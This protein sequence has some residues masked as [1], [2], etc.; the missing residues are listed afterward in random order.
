[1]GPATDPPRQEIELIVESRLDNVALLGA[2][3]SGIASLLGWNDSERFNLELCAV[4]AATNCVRHAYGGEAGHP[5]RLRIRIDGER[6]ELR[7]ADRGRPIPQERRARPVLADDPSDPA[8]FAE[9]GRGL[10]LMHALMD[11]VAF[12]REDGWNV[13]SL[14]RQRRD[15]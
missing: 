7:I 4:E 3:V 6:F 1:M 14:V 10:F 8:T 5:V 15:A 9:G 13:L 2:A 11:E 12:L